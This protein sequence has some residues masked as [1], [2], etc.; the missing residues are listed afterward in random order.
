MGSTNLE[1]I[2]QRLENFERMMDLVKQYPIK[3]EKERSF[4]P[5]QRNY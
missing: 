3:F 5:Y 1:E 2:M 4:P